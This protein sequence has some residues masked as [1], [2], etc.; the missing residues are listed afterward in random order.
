[1]GFFSWKCKGCSESIK[2]PYGLPKVWDFMNEAVLLESKGSVIHGSYDGYGN[3][4][5]YEI[6]YDPLDPE[7]WH[8]KCWDKAGK[9]AYTG[10][11]ENAEDQGFFYDNPGE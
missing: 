2:A 11:S 8:K 7:L 4:G 5:N 3:V 6:S 9:P 1:M 10:P